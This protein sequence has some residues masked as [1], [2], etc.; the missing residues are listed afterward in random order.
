MKVDLNGFQVFTCRDRA[1]NEFWR[2]RTWGKF[3]AAIEKERDDQVIYFSSDSTTKIHPPSLPQN[4]SN[5]STRDRRQNKH[6]P[7]ANTDMM[8]ITNIPTKYS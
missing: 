4:K 1:V 3:P 6:H 2:R 8:L 7:T 5:I